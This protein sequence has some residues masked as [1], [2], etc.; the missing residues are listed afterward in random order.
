MP[1]YIKKQEEQKEC[2]QLSHRIAHLKLKNQKIKGEDTIKDD[3]ITQL[4]EEVKKGVHLKRDLA[5]KLNE[6]KNKAEKKATLLALCIE[7]FNMEVT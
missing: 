4:K 7:N 6:Q 5:K 1:K 3:W 2:D